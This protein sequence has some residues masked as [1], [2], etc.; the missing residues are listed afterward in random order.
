[1]KDLILSIDFIQAEIADI[2]NAI[3]LR[4]AWS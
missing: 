1:M 3:N 2:H 4:T